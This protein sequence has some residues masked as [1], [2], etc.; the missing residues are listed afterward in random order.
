MAWITYWALKPC[1]PK[2]GDWIHLA[3]WKPI[4]LKFQRCKKPRLCCEEHAH[5]CLLLKQ[6]R[7]S[8]LKVPRSRT[9]FSDWI[10][11]CPNL[12]RVPLLTL[13][14]CNTT[15]QQAEGCSSQGEQIAVKEEVSNWMCQGQPLLEPKE[16]VNQGGVHYFNWYDFTTLGWKLMILRRVPNCGG[17]SQIRPSTISK[18][19]KNGHSWCS[20]RWRMVRDLELWLM[21]WGC[22]ACILA[23]TQ[24]SLQPILFQHC[25]PIGWRHHSWQW[26]ECT[27]TGNRTSLES[28]LRDS[29]LAPWDP[30]LTTIS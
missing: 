11:A 24:C 4:G 23:H 26:E 3:G 9:H 1:G 16:A 13:L 8:R 29:A 20:W 5:A 25:S 10:R 18:W 2:L 19:D 6:H 21:W 14:F 17:W 22:T 30:P 15:P 27:S 7:G 12:R 28:S